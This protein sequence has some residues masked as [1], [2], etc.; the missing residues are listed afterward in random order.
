MYDVTTTVTDKMACKTTVFVLAYS[1]LVNAKRFCDYTFDRPYVSVANST[2]LRI[3]WTG[4]FNEACD[5]GQV[6]S[7]QIKIRRRDYMYINDPKIEYM[8]FN[9]A[10]FDDKTIEL[11]QIHV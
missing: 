10:T 7:A 2:H 9:Y 3:N 5:D 4:S 11:K 8:P 6:K 1:A